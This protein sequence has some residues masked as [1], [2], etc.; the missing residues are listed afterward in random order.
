MSPVAFICETE[1]ERADDLSS[2][3]SYLGSMGYDVHSRRDLCSPAGQRFMRD[4]PPDD[5]RVVLICP[6]ELGRE[7]FEGVLGPEDHFWSF[8]VQG[9]PKDLAG[10]IQSEVMLA[11]GNVLGSSPVRKVM[12]I[13]GGVGGVYAALDIAEQGYPVVL[14]ER[15][16]SI[17]GIMAAF[18][19]T[20]PTMDCSI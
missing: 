19:K 7:V 6:R 10:Y 5:E 3:S 16:P 9:E 11:S 1:S 13:G 8:G 20:F 17:G 14:V 18:D 12:V 2:L 15:D 4:N